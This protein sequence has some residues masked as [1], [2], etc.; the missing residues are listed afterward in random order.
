[1]IFVYNK[2]NYYLCIVMKQSTSHINY[3]KHPRTQHL[4]WSESL[5]S[6]DKM[7]QDIIVFDGKE[8]IATEKMDGENTS[9]YT[10]YVHARSIDSNNHP[11]RNWVKGLWSEIGYN[12][13]INWRLCGENLFAKHSIHYTEENG[14]PLESYFY[15]FSIWN[16]NNICL[17]WDET[18]KWASLLGLTT[19]PVLYDGI[20]DID[21]I[22]NI[23][24]TN[25]E[26]YVLRIKD[27]FHYS[28]FKTS[29]AKYVRKNHVQTS[30]H[31]T[32]EKIIRNEKT[33]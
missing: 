11:S 5:T 3:I 9:M 29:V 27:E 30:K 15:M 1:M 12:I 4:P 18:I 13:P 17:S 25:K 8:V 21:A 22:K 16:N 6:D 28:D 20:F 24:I 23:D 2:N 10:D 26:G 7:I 31:W 32:S 19:V 33:T 14:N